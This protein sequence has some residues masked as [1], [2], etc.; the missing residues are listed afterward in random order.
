MKKF[1]ISFA[2][3]IAI[4][5]STTNLKADDHA[6]QSYFNFQVNFCKLNDG[7][8]ME[9]Y[10]NAVNNYIK[11]SKKNDVE[12]FVARQTPLFPH[13]NFVSDRGFDFQEILVGP[14]NT[15]G[16]AWDLWLGTKEGQKLAK[17]WQEAADCYVKWGHAYPQYLD[18]KALDSGNDR[19][20]SWNWC[21][22]KD[23]VSLE[24]LQARHQTMVEELEKDNIGLSGW[25]IVQPVT[26]GAQ[27]PGGF[28][29]LGIYDD[30]ESF[31]EY[32][33][34]FAAG[35]WVNYIDYTENYAS[36]IGEELYSEQILNRP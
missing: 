20:V 30:V 10:S 35:G 6:E 29:H 19:V 13:D 21:T 36:C 18:Q 34:A 28:V 17:N 11:W 24:D 33:D 7:S 22:R 16:K 4:I 32:K 26:G 3:I 27:A 15:T 1:L 2:A 12:V 9:D 5:S 14:H 8:S 25:V 23:G 31:M